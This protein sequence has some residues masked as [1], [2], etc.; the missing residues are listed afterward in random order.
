MLTT[1]RL[2]SHGFLLI[3]FATECNKNMFEI[4]TLLSPPTPRISLL[5]F[6]RFFF[7]LLPGFFKKKFELGESEL[8]HFSSSPMNP[9]ALKFDIHPSYNNADHFEAK[10]LHLGPNK[11]LARTSFSEVECF[12]PPPLR[13]PSFFQSFLYIQL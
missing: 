13:Y 10:Q 3:R 11:L 2:I 12:T 9:Q 8:L 5:D 6:H 4:H 1:T 7:L